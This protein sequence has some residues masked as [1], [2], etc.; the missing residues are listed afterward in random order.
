MG[1]GGWI[2]TIQ[3]SLPYR[4]LKY[5]LKIEKT[6]FKMMQHVLKEKI[7]ILMCVELCVN[8]QLIFINIHEYY[9]FGLPPR[10]ISLPIDTIVDYM[11]LHYLNC[12]E[13]PSA[14]L[15]S[16]FN[17]SANNRLLNNA[18]VSTLSFSLATW[19]PL[20]TSCFG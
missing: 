5:S 4:S 3:F 6:D 19:L 8:A 20:C 2:N 11:K 14:F 13:I 17:M 1:G 18:G 7:L 15:V 10:I 9:Q 16:P 12:D